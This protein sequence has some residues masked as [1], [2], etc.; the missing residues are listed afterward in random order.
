[1]TTRVCTLTPDMDVLQ[2]VD[3]LLK[4]RISGAPVVNADNQVV[5]VLSE[6]DCLRLVAGGVDGEEA[7]GTVSDFMSP[8]VETI[9][10]TSGTGES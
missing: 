9:P 3:V 10:P 7:T 5:G 6:K 1:M 4:N 8:E 2:A